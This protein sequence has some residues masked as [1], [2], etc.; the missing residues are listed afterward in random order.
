MSKEPDIARIYL[1]GKRG[2]CSICSKLMD[3]AIPHIGSIYGNRL[4]TWDL[5]VNNY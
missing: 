1:F 5:Q 2:A 4:Q 3:L